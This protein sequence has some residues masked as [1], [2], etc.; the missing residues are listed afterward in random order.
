MN[1]IVPSS[2]LATP[3]AAAPRDIAFK[4]D[5]VAL[6]DAWKAVSEAA[7][8]GSMTFV[9][10]ASE[11]RLQASDELTVEGFVPITDAAGLDAGDAFHLD[12]AE[13]SF[14][15]LAIGALPEIG[16]ILLDGLVAEEGFTGVLR[17]E[18]AFTIQCP[19][20]LTAV[21]V[22]AFTMEPASGIPVDPRT[23]RSA[24]SEIRDFA[25]VD[26][27][28]G[29]SLG[30]L[31]IVSEEARGMSPAACHSIISERLN[32]IEMR[33]PASCAKILNALLGQ[34]KPDS[35]KLT[36]T[37]NHHILYDGR[38]R[39]TLPTAPLL[40]H[41]PD[42]KEVIGQLQVDVT[43]FTDAI[44]VIAAQATSK[45]TIAVLDV[46]EHAEE[47][48]FSVAVQG[49]EAVMSCPVAPVNRS[50]STQVRLP[51]IARMRSVIRCPSRRLGVLF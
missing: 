36:A 27:G 22:D 31:Q 50:Q 13:D 3:Q 39:V 35:T 37:A 32:A 14:A 43:E 10:S 4:V 25:G 41:W 38:I 18:T 20:T 21:G 28:A 16:I 19:F 42:L 26:G 51:F 8:N 23:I 46:E 2:D 34:L 44:E 1:E 30:T 6:R 45:D 7:R 29:Y 12:L 15:A 5:L 48:T 33:F 17:L 24:V 49:G 11:V 40:P 9:V 47:L